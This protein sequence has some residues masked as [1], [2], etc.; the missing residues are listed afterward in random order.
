MGRQKYDGKERSGLTP[1]D[2]WEHEVLEDDPLAANPPQP[3]R[4]RFAR[5][6]R[7]EDTQVPSSPSA[8]SDE[9]LSDPHPWPGP[10]AEEDQESEET[11][12]SEQDERDYQRMCEKERRG[13][14]WISISSTSPT[15]P[16]PPPLPPAETSSVDTAGTSHMR[17]PR[18]EGNREGMR[19]SRDDETRASK[20][21]HIG[22]PLRQRG[23]RTA[24]AQYDGEDGAAAA[25]LKGYL[26]HATSRNK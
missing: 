10:R 15:P 16:P 2:N 11:N 3:R 20:R 17:R 8:S 18:D 25:N 24:P 21:A 23:K 26:G 5:A 19:S 7:A 13:H 9:A 1:P 6:I 14:S 12:T 4:R 22:P